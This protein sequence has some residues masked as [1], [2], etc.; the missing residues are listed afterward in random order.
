ML[1]LRRQSKPSGFITGSILISSLYHTVVLITTDGG[2][3]WNIKYQ[4]NRQNEQARKID[5][6][7]SQ[8]GYI[9][10]ERVSNPQRFVLKTINGGNNWSELAFPSYNETSIGFINPITGWIGG[11]FNPGFG[12]TDGGASWFNANIGQDIMEFFL[13]GDTLGYAC[14]QY[15]YKYEKTNGIIQT[16]SEVPEKFE[17]LQNYPNPFNPVTHISFSIAERS[18]VSITIYDITGKLVAL[19][20]R[21]TLAPGKYE[22]RFEAVNLNSGVY[23]CRINAGGTYATKKMMLVK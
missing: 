11:S 10:L 8:T 13:F 5:F 17:L 21:R 22:Y 2:N 18:D 4:G 6:A 1:T 16:S 3:N 20:E 7:D 9:A 14:G 19:T 12:T 23:I 15:I